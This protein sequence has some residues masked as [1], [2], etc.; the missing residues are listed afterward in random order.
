M[1]RNEKS[2]APVIMFASFETRKETRAA[3]SSGVV[4]LPMGDPNDAK[5]AAASLCNEASS[6][7]ANIELPLAA[8]SL[9]QIKIR[10]DSE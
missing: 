6:V 8:N 2:A 5:V 1:K 4:S 10:I 9:C 3:T 7:I